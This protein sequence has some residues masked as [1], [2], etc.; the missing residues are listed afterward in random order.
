M[1]GLDAGD[2]LELA[3]ARSGPAGR[4]L[5]ILERAEPGD[6]QGQAA[7]ALGARDARLMAVRAANFGPDVELVSSCP[8]CAASLQLTVRAADVGLDYEPPAAEPRE[9]AIAG[10]RVRL[11]PVTAGDLA[12]AEAGVD[13][14]AARSAILGRCVLAVDEAPGASLPEPLG[15][16]IE[17]ALEVMDPQAE[18]ILDL[19]CP[20]CGADWSE[21]FDPAGVLASDVEHAARR[22]MAEVAALARVYHWSEAEIL[23]LPPMRRR[24]YLD[25]AG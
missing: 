6:P 11:R 13:V 1:R 18:V 21:V 23:A 4:A 16:A 3:S 15:A 20:G 10:R 14:A 9:L 12:A 19:A 25:A 5:A 2:I 22:L 8:D 7:L 17:A 24:Y